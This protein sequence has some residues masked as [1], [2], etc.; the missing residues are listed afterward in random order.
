[1]NVMAGLLVWLT[2]LLTLL[3]LFGVFSLNKHNLN[4]NLIAI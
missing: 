3:L 1:M 2:L 4:L